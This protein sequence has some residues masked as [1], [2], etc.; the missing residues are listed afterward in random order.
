MWFIIL[1]VI[2]FILILAF[3]SSDNGNISPAQYAA[4]TA[5]GLVF[6]V[7]VVI[8]I[9]YLIISNF[10]AIVNIVSLVTLIAMLYF[11][12]VFI[13]KGKK[14]SEQGGEVLLSEY[15]KTPKDLDDDLKDKIK[16]IREK[17]SQRTFD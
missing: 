8:I 7:P 12:V 1:F 6:G 17:T 11:V 3:S 5:V 2:L 4:R 9:A 13:Q 14:V 15:L 16:K 10:E